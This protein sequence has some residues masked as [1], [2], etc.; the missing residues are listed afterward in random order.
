MHTYAFDDWTKVSNHH[1]RMLDDDVEARV[2]CM[3]DAAMS[4]ARQA[5]EVLF[6][7]LPG[8]FLERFSCQQQTIVGQEILFRD[9]TRRSFEILRISVFHRSVDFETH[10][11]VCMRQIDGERGK[12]IWQTLAQVAIRRVGKN[13]EWIFNFQETLTLN[14]MGF[15]LFFFH[16]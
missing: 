3:Q 7:L 15:C 6:V 8:E 4:P 9:S 5:F 13:A 1:L 10:R 11:V 14:V 2:A 12:A 16:F